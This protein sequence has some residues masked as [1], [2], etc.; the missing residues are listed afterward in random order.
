MCAGVCYARSLAFP[1]LKPNPN[2]VSPKSQFAQWPDLSLGNAHATPR[3]ALPKILA[4]SGPPFR[5][6]AKV[7][8][9][10]RTFLRRTKWNSRVL[11]GSLQHQS[12]VGRLKR[13]ARRWHSQA[14]PILALRSNHRHDDSISATRKRC[15]EPRALTKPKRRL[16]LKSPFWF[17]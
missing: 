11:R 8:E 9:S 3:R 5:R 12:E 13:C 15:L 6:Q 7:R 16:Q 4:G 1:R 2:C 10:G 14:P 17:C